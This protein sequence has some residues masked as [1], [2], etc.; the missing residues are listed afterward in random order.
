M[1]AATCALLVALAVLCVLF[2]RPQAQTPPDRRRKRK[3]AP[4]PPP[5]APRPTNPLT[6][7]F[8][9]VTWS[10]LGNLLRCKAEMSRLD[11]ILT[12]LGPPA[13]LGAQTAVPHP[14]PP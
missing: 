4:E 13:A 10:S 5:A 12:D 2:L 8:G 9:G 3:R 11:D 7:L 14:A 1:R 6:A